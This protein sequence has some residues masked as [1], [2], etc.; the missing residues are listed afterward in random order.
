MVNLVGVHRL[1]KA[2]IVDDLPKVG[3]PF[4]E[5]GAGLAMP[6]ELGDRRHDQL[7]LVGGH[8]RDAL[9]LA[10]RVRQLL[11]SPFEQ[12]GFVVEQFELGGA[13]RLRQED[14]PFGLGGKVG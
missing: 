12:A 3:E 2:N 10:D 6:D 11:A 9:A 5:L 13:A 14:D 7:L 8:R 4:A 1:H